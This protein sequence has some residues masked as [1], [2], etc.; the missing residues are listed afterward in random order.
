MNHCCRYDRRP[1][2]STVATIADID[3]VEDADIGRSDLDHRVHTITAG[4]V[5]DGVFDDGV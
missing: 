3:V 1:T 2:A 5:V 4:T